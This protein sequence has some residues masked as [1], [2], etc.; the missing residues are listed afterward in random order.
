M[1]LQIEPFPELKKQILPFQAPGL[2]ILQRLKFLYLNPF[3]PFQSTVPVATFS[4]LLT[5]VNSY[6]LYEISLYF[7]ISMIFS[8]FVSD[9]YNF[10]MDVFHIYSS[11]NI[12]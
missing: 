7:P 12:A 8:A 2:L 3:L 4:L 10:L 11:V 9:R 1:F 5:K 6:F